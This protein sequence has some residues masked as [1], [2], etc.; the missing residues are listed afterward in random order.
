MR[1]DPA[2]GLYVHVPFC[3]GKCPYCDFYSVTAA[4]RIPAFL[5]GIGR[6]AALYQGRFPV[7]DTLYIGGGTPSRLDQSQV[8][9][10]LSRL[11]ALPLAPDAEVTFEVNSEDA[12]LNYLKRLVELGVNR[13]SLGVQSLDDEELKFLGR[14]HT[15]GQALQALEAAR[16]AGLANLS[17]D[18]IYGLP[19]RDVSGWLKTLAAILDRRPEHLSCYMLTLEK[20]TPLARLE[21]ERAFVMP[22]EDGARDFFLATSRFLEERGYHHYEVSSFARS[23]DRE[24]RHNR[25][26]WNH[27]PYLGLGPAAHSFRKNER[28]WN[29]RSLNRWLQALAE[30]R[31][32]VAGRELLSEDQMN[33]EKILLGL[34]TDKG[35]DL[36]TAATP[37]ARRLAE[38]WQTEGLARIENG[39]LI[40]TREGLV[41]AD[42][43]ALE[44]AALTG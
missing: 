41:L 3:S 11:K 31:S 18:L 9:T 19:G 17:L 13:L 44:M 32:P 23:S 34:R 12:D 40:L 24:S 1:T 33:M 15:A 22:G 42:R 39:R 7:F 20:G 8:E 43:L 29:E 37:Q 2:P 26:Y 21:K 35:I 38:N 30:N 4:K 25:K 6:E 10:L 5:D 27:T 36:A 16:S 28:W 14:R